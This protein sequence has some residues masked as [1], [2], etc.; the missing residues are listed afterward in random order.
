MGYAPE[1]Y[2]LVSPEAPVDPDSDDQ[3]YYSLIYVD[4]ARRAQLDI[5]LDS[6]SKVFQNL[7]HNAGINLGGGVC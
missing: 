4:S 3:L 2:S 1:M 6:Q 7:N 5:K